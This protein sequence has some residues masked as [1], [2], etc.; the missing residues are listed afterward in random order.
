MLQQEREC[1]VHRF[2]VDGM[3]VVEEKD[4]ALWNGRK[5]VQQG[6]QHRLRRWRHG[7]LEHARHALTDLRGDRLQGC[8]EV[9][10]EARR[11][12]VPFVQ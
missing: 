5:V 2:G 4:D 11:I 3:V 9:G 12:A 6:R 10:Q 8:D 1:F 7:R